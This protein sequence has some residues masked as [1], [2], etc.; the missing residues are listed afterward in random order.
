MDR[1]DLL[2]DLYGCD[3]LDRNGERVG[4]VADV[5]L[6]D[7]RPLW[8]AVRTDDAV[9][10]VPIRGAQVHDRRVVVP[11]EKREIEEAPR[12]GEELSDLEHVELHDHYGLVVP[13][14][15]LVRRE[16]P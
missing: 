2:D 14:Q 10:L 7:G 5:W 8:A 15:R 13:S 6:D 11:V 16:R 3:L 4:T 9:T 12:V 1:T